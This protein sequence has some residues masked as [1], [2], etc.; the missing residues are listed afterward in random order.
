M[1]SLRAPDV[2]YEH[3]LIDRKKKG[4]VG[5]GSGFREPLR[6]GWRLL[7]TGGVFPGKHNP[8]SQR[9]LCHNFSMRGFSVSGYQRI[10]KDMPDSAAER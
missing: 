9:L 3:V 7:I 8:A 10:S 4:L 1:T 2:S 6:V 5:V